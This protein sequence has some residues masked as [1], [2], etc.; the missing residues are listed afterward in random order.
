MTAASLPTPGLDPRYAHADEPARGR[1]HGWWWK[2]LL[3]GALLWALAIAA[4]V[5]TLNTNLVPT[6][7]LIGS[8]LVPFSVVLFAAER[9]SSGY[10]VTSLIIAFFVG[11][12]LGVLG[13]SLL[14]APLRVAGLVGFLAIGLIEELVKGV[15][16]VLMGLRLRP[17]TAR[18]GALLGATVGG[19]F[20]AFESAGYAF[21]AALGTRGIDLLSLLQ[22]EAIRAVLSPL[23]HVLWTAVLGA[24]IF[25]AS[26]DGRS[27]RFR[28]A[29]PLVYLLVAV[30]HALWDSMG[31]ISTVVAILVTGNAVPAFEYDTLRAGTAGEVGA[32]TTGV[33]AAGLGVVSV[34]GGIALA[35]AVRRHRGRDRALSDAFAAEE[36]AVL[37]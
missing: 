36:R 34:I 11:G 20:A 30:L 14:E 22:T 26:R 6:L 29:I 8:F 31:G 32:I 3:V 33:Y 23:G 7:I 27:Y 1:R 9:M 12:V 16:L 35:V 13:A 17:K 2:S 24:V 5:V 4:T 18:Q 25:G 10:P 19:G 15:V 21:N 28:W 37:A